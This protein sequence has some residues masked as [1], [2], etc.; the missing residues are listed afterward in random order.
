MQDALMAA[1]GQQY[2]NIA[3]PMNTTLSSLYSGQLNPMKS[4]D[5]LSGANARSAQSAGQ[6][7]D[8]GSKTQQSLGNFITNAAFP[9]AVAYDP[10]RMG[11]STMGSNAGKDDD[12]GG[13]MDVVKTGLSIASL[14]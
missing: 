12:D 8:A 11:V 7:I 4:I 9:T 10:T 6:L 3:N 1:L 14:F 2:A 5:T 13:F